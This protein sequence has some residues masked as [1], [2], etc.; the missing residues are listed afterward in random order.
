VIGVVGGSGFYELMDDVELRRVETPFG[1]PA[2]DVSIGL[3][4]GRS[5]AFLPRHGRDHRFV[6]HRVPYRAN[7]WALHSVGVTSL[8]APCSVGSLQPDLHP[9]QL[10]VVDQ[11]VDRT[12]G[13]ADT[14]HDV[15]APNGEPGSQPPVHHQAFAEPYDASLRRDV[16]AAGRRC[17]IDLVD[18]ATMVVINGPRFSTRAESV[19]FR[20]MGW[21]VVNMTGYPEAVL[22]AELGIR[23]ASIALVT[24]HDAG[25]DG[26][27]SVTMDAVFAVMRSNVGRVRELIG[28]VVMAAA[29]P[30]AS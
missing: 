10:V 7:I 22:A 13:R 9:G 25:V 2:D 28:E 24:D 4:G 19:W 15:G 29:E 27:E 26:F 12:H 6:A 8:L 18:G 5:V 16:V 11:L 1:D 14:Y 3:I 23:Y 30:S 21:H 20:Q 17:E